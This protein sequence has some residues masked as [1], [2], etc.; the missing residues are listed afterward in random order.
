MDWFAETGTVLAVRPRGVTRKSAPNFPHDPKPFE[1]VSTYGSVVALMHG[2]A[3]V[4]GVNE[5]GLQVSGLYLSV[6]DYGTRDPERPGLELFSAIQCLLDRFATVE[7]AVKDIETLRVQLI[8]MRIDGKPGTGHIS[9]ADP[10]GD[11]A[12]IE[13]LKGRTTVH[14]GDKYTVMTNEPEYDAQLVNLGKYEGFGG[15]QPL[16]GGVKPTD[17]FVRAAYYSKQLPAASDAQEAAAYV[18]SV[19]RNA[20]APFGIVDDDHPNVSPTR[21]RTV[22]DCTDRRYFFESTRSP[23][24]VWVELSQ[25]DLAEGRP[26]LILDLVNEPDRVGNVTG[27]FVAAGS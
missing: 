5:A 24:V 17:R 25:L 1:W 20:S 9:L 6:S 19:I 21:W 7:E 16:P 13:F 2:E 18:F 12:I 23:N 4:D 26:E 3:V 14:H 11:S 8:E 15:V 10:T 27:E 22:T